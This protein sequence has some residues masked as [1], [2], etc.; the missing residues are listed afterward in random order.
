MTTNVSY[1]VHKKIKRAENE[2]QII[3]NTQ[4]AI[5]D[6]DT[7]N[8]V[9]KLREHRRRKTASGR[10]SI[11]SG[12]VYCGDCGSKMYF[13]V[14]KSLNE[15][16]DF[17]RCSACKENRGACQIH[18]IRNTMLYEMVLNMIRQIADFI[19]QY[20][21]IFL[22]L[23]TQKHQLAKAQNLRSAKQ[24]IEQIKKRISE[25]DKL[26]EQ[27]Y[28]DNVLGKISDERFSRMSANYEAEQKRLIDEA[29]KA[30]VEIINA[31]KESVDLKVFLKAIRKCTDISELTPTLVNTLIQKIEIF[32]PERID[33]VKH[34]P[35]KIHFT[36]VGIIDIPD[37]K[38]IL[39]VIQEIQD[40]AQKSA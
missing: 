8:R 10:T 27:I 1:K 7:F 36:A 2:R 9:Q 33:G 13:C 11:F 34:V 17:F 20:E 21:P 37:E 30:E 5:I 12:L 6:E 15:K 38:E 39:K 35:I 19:M 25:L 4:E 31:E 29:N 14:A 23:Y 3:P 24:K 40:D 22:Y 32:N 16:Q 18:Y 28:E 26:I